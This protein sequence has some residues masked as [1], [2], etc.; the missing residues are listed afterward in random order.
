[1]IMRY[2]VMESNDIRRNLATEEYLMDTADVTEPLLLLYIQNPCIIIGRNQ[3]AYEEIDLNYLRQHQIV[4][5]RRVSGGGA[6]YDDLGNISFSFV[7]KKGD[8]TFGDYRGVTTPILEALRSMGAKEATSGGRND[9]YMGDKKFSGNAMYTKKGRTYSHGTLM[10]DVDLTVL[11]KVLTVSKEKIA[12]KATQSVPKSVTNVKPYL[13]PQFQAPTI[14]AFRDELI[15]HIYQ[16]NLLKEISDKKLELTDEDRQ[17]IQKLVDKRYANDDWVYG[18]APNFEF[19]QRTR[20][21]DVGIVDVHL[22]TEKGKISAIQFF[23]DFFGT[24]DIEGL[25]EILQGVTYKYE[26]IKDALE[27]VDVSEYIF[28]FSNQALLDLLMK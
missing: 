3:N 8:T 11:D 12:S 7:T 26:T 4:L 10:Y 6:V 24:K 23:G 16:V 20:L 2:H 14:E 13:A 28:N 5:T 25:E 19:N 21:A 18:Q 15:C 27:G 1:M 9:L 17:G 22:S